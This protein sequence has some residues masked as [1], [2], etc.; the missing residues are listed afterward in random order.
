MEAIDKFYDE[1]EIVED[2]DNE[3]DEEEEE[4]EEDLY[5]IKKVKSGGTKYSKI[6]AAIGKFQQNGINV[7]L[8][9]IN[10]SAFTFTPDVKTN[11][12]YFGLEVSFNMCVSQ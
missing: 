3:T 1:Q 11:T 10:T 12:I 7:S 5:S 9:N 6:A 2:E 4:V 8:P